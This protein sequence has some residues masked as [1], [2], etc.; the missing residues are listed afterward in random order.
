ME[1]FTIK[2]FII[3]LTIVLFSISYAIVYFYRNENSLD[4]NVN[5]RSNISVTYDE[6]IINCTQTIDN[7]N[8]HID[9]ENLM[10]EYLKESGMTTIT[11]S[12]T[13]NCTNREEIDDKGIFT[14]DKVRLN[15]NY[16]EDSNNIKLREILKFLKL[17]FVDILT[18]LH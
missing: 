18:F 15:G 16:L 2:K 8:L 7:D 3:I 12:E 13:V 17:F 14:V 10:I 1:V 11:L 5:N 4:I 9:I 6:K